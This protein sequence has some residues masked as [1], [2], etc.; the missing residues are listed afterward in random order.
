MKKLTIVLMV[1]L[2]LFANSIFSQISNYNL[3]DYKVPN[4]KR[5]ALSTNFSINS[6]KNATKEEY[7]DTITSTNNE[8]SSLDINSNIS[9][10][11][12]GYFNLDKYQGNQSFKTRT[13]PSYSVNKDSI[14]TTNESFSKNI[15]LNITSTN[16]YYLHKKYF[17]GFHP[18]LIITNNNTNTPINE[19]FS[20]KKHKNKNVFTSIPIEIGYGRIEQVQNARLAIYIF[21][22]LLEKNILSRT[23]SNDEIQEFADLIST[24]LNER[25]LDYRKKKMYEISMI[26]KFLQEKKLISETNEAYLT[27]VYDNWEN[28]N[29]P[30]R[31]SGYRFSLG[32]SNDFSKNIYENET[33]LKQ[34]TNANEYNNESVRKTNGFNA[35]FYFQ[36]PINLKWQSGTYIYGS[37]KK[38]NTEYSN[39]YLNTYED[40]TIKESYTNTYSSLSITEELGYYPNSRTSINFLTSFRYSTQIDEKDDYDSKYGD[41]NIYFGLNAYYYISD[42]LQ[43]QGRFTYS[44]FNNQDEFEYDTY[45]VD[46]NNINKDENISIGLTYLF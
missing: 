27:I 15:Y 17:L 31:E 19:N 23:P 7:K 13:S 39:K 38:G 35:T 33:T 26:D 28:A 30:V 4:L 22:D 41:L 21:N 43:L 5:H 3:S 37:I 45:R 29:Q 16:R 34:S 20:D 24:V 18:T 11:Y 46:N 42:H 14:G 1:L 8:H 2:C 36:K 10:G 40:T 25:I 32:F 44:L 9:L 12:Y 6:T